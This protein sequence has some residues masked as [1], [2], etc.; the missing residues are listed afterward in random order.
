MK[1]RFSGDGFSLSHHNFMALLWH[2]GFL[3]FAQNFMDID[4]VIPA[5]LIEAGGNAVHVG[6]M[7]AIL[8]GGSSFTQIIFAPYLS[9]REHKK[10]F[11]LLGI[12][13]R[14]LSLLGLGDPVLH[15][16]FSHPI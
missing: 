13:A 9:N 4:T 12:N 14:I 10:K 6:I 11:L 16:L 7:S 8:L 5:M 15:K 2:A 3:A 1:K